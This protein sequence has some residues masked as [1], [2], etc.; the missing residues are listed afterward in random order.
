MISRESF[1]N[2]IREL[3][4]T[5]KSRQKRT[6]LWRKKGGTHCIMVPLRDKLDDEFVISS[7]HQAGLGKEEVQ[8]FLASAKS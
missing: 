4:Y 3:R 7:L 1:V 2:K 6:E 8:A 5:Y